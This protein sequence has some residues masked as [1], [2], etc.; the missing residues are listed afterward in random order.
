MF[1][2]KAEMLAAIK[3]A[4]TPQC[5]LAMNGPQ[6]YNMGKCGTCTGGCRGLCKTT[7]SGVVHFKSSRK[8]PKNLLN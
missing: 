4:L 2:I 7:C 3:N 8:F 6:I 5:E 1:Q